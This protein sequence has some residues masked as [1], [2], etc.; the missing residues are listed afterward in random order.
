MCN[1]QQTNANQIQTKRTKSKTK[2]TKQEVVLA[3]VSHQ[4]VQ[5]HPDRQHKQKHKPK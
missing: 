1:T 5:R 2:L 3:R 4:S